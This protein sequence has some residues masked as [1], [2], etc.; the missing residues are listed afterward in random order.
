MNISMVLIL[1]CGLYIT[2]LMRSNNTFLGKTIH[3]RGNKQIKQSAMQP[4]CILSILYSMDNNKQRLSS[5]PTD[6]LYGSHHTQVSFSTHIFQYKTA[7][8]KPLHRIHT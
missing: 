6:G 2:V 3:A 4:Q 5:P 7:N 1:I 8:P